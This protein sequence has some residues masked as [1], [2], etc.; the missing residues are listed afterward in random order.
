MRAAGVRAQTVRA[1]HANLFLSPVFREAFVN[2]GSLTLE[3]YDTDAAQGAARGAGLGAGVY[4]SPEEAF[5][6]LARLS[7]VEPTPALQA[8]YQEAFASW[9]ALLAREQAKATE[10]QPA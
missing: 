1:G 7:T 6:G 4:A 5:T 8:Q 2:C 9:Q 3:L 10:W